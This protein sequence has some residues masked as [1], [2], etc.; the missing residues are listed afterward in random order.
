MATVATQLNSASGFASGEIVTATKLNNL[1]N[2][3][4]VTGIVNADIDAAAAIAAS[5]LALTGAITDTQLATGAVTGA[6]GGGKIAAS[7]ITGQT[8]IADPLASGDEFLVHDTSASA[9]RRVAFNAIQPVGSVL[10]TVYVE[11]TARTTITDLIPDNDTIPQITQGAQVLTLNITPSS[12]S[13]KILLTSVACVGHSSN[14]GVAC[15]LFRTG[16]S[17]ALCTVAS[18]ATAD[19]TYN[20]SRAITYMDSPNSVSQ[21]TYSLRIGS[22]VTGTVLNNWYG[23]T[24]KYGQSIRTTLMAQE[25]KG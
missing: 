2:T 10:Q 11:T 25:I 24:N 21:V 17:N 6:A 13:S 8:T 1:V 15:C 12:T 4:T 7:A 18:P 20:P 9:L 23:A 19:D 22:Y 3:A 5:K 16:T 14:A